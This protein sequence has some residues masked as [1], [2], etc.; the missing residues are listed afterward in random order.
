M[1]I[2]KRLTRFAVLLLALSSLFLGGCFDLGDFENEEQYY[3]SFG[4]VSLIGKDKVQ[5]SY[6]LSEYFYNESTVNDF[7]CNIASDEYIYFAVPFSRDMQVDS[8]TLF[9]NCETTCSF[10][11]SAFIVT[12]LPTNIRGY[13]DPEYTVR[14]D[15]EGNPLLDEH[16]NEIRDYI[17]Y[18]DPK[19]EGALWSDSFSAKAGNW[20]SFCIDGWYTGALNV[21]GTKKKE[22]YITAHMGEILLIRFENNGGYGA[23]KGYIHVPFKTTDMLIRAKLG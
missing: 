19:T 4:L 10:N 20:T 17:V 18:D 11:Y 7:E 2:K 13:A 23:D 1:P 12:S 15:S 5:K 8:F 3:L 6:S 16:G 22:N 14:K 21:D 9:I